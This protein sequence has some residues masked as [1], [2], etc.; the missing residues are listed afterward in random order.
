MVSVG[1][2]SPDIGGR[3]A[4]ARGSTAISLS[5]SMVSAPSGGLRVVLA[6]SSPRRR[7]LLSG[8][9]RDFV[10]VPS[11][12]LEP[13]FTG[14]NVHE[15]VRTLARAKALHVAE[16][17]PGACV[18]GAD[19]V[20]LCGGQVLGKPRDV[21]DARAMLTRL[22]GAWHEVLTGIC[23]ISSTGRTFDDCES[24][25]V[26]FARLG[27]DEIE[28]LVQT[29]EPFD[30]AGAYAIQGYA[31][32]F[33]ERIEGDYSNVVGLPLRRLYQLLLKSGLDPKVCREGR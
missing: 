28:W 6:S 3:R 27:T 8:I 19:T 9:L 26:K 2:F 14:G 11:G 33:I 24:T 20:V 10:V 25:R 13:A 4:V 32:M 1:P 22:S 16:D 7:E 18:I 30:K 23:V 5:E 17:E 21:E 12:A 31:A 15:F 29:R